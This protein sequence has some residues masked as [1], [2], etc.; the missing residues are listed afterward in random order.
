[1]MP[2]ELIIL[3]AP[4]VVRTKN[5][6]RTTL[7][8]MLREKPFSDI[9]VLEIAKGAHIN[10]A[11]FY[12]HFQDKYVLLEDALRFLYR[13]RLSALNRSSPSEIAVFI[14]PVAVA[15]FGLFGDNHLQIGAKLHGH[16]ERAMQDE[17]CKFI[18][19]FFGESAAIVVSAAVITLA[20][21]WR[22]SGCKR[23]I[24]EIV[25]HLVAVLSEGVEVRPLDKPKLR[26]TSE[27]RTTNRRL[28][29]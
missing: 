1:M 14:E 21:Q 6:I 17:L 29:A 25:R 27:A 13:D 3:E 11:T 5:L 12:A 8:R 16:L 19:P 20:M 24:Q 23:V 22:G 4:R 2:N 18:L 9:S 28:P 10:R 7:L 26:M 15:T